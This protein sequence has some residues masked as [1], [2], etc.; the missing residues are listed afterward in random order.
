MVGRVNEGLTDEVM[1]ELNARVDLDKKT[2]EDGGGP[3]P[4]GVRPGR[5]L[6]SAKWAVWG[7]RADPCRVGACG[8][9]APA[10][11]SS[12]RRAGRGSS[13]AAVLVAEST[14]ARRVLETSQPP[15]I[16]FPPD[17][18][19]MDLL[20]AHEQ[21][22]VCEW[23]GQA[24]YWTLAGAPRRP[25]GPTPSLWPWPTPSSRDHVAFYPQRRGRLLPR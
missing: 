7:I 9:S 5:R 21:R 6:A 3:V 13:T 22:T 17:D 25:R 20:E 12:S 14:R 16:Y 8:L 4:G 23:K 1:Q 19:R 15:G 11:P 24:S 18:V 2:P 10:R